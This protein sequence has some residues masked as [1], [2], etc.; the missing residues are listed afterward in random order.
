[1]IGLLYI[2][3]VSLEIYLK[4]KD[5]NIFF[6]LILREFKQFYF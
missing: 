6:H 1:M 5:D 3:N 2:N 4:K